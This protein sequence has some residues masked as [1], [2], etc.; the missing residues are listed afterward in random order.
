MAQFDAVLDFDDSAAR[1]FAGIAAELRRKGRPA[2]DMDVLIAATAMAGGH[3]LV[4]RNTAHFAD[5]PHLTVE[6]Y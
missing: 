2:G 5:I 4:T 6:T 1:L 3:S